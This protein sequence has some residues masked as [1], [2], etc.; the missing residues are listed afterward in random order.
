V[1]NGGELDIKQRFGL[2]IKQRRHE[3]GI[4]QEELAYRASLHRTYVSDIERGMRNVS[5]E[6]I[7]KLAKALNIS[8]SALFA[9][10]NV[11]IDE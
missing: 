8:I 1:R 2:A 7:A 4:S 3:L 10:Y 5:I 11:E 6:N 9:N